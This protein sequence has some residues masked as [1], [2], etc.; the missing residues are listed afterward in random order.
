MRRWLTLAANLAELAVAFEAEMLSRF[1]TPLWGRQA[2][3]DCTK[4]KGMEMNTENNGDALLNVKTLATMLG[5]HQRTVWH[6]DA[7]GKVPRP[8]HLATRTVRWRRSEINKWIDAGC[9]ARE[10]WEMLREE[11]VGKRA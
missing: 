8:I 2:A 11:K 5:V 7:A 9:P 10:K 6:M 3:G 1:P 4:T